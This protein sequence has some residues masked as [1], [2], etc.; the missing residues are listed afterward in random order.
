[1]PQ[2]KNLT[3]H[4]L[5]KDIKRMSRTTRSSSRSSSSGLSDLDTPQSTNTF[6]QIYGIL[7]TVSSEATTLRNNLKSVSKRIATKALSEK[8]LQPKPH[9]AAWFEEHTLKSPCRLQEFLD[10]FLKIPAK[11]GRISIEARTIQLSPS[12][13]ALF[14]IEPIT[15]TWTDV[16]QHLPRVFQ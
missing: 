14:M 7:D 3:N 11:E 10:Q 1:M 5:K 12:E 15:Y 16:L 8:P 2:A 4:P 13:A 9:A 6:K